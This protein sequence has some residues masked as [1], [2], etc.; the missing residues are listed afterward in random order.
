M[1]WLGG[2]VLTQNVA[3]LLAVPVAVLCMDLFLRRVTTSLLARV[4]LSLLYGFSP[5]VIS[6]L[7]VSHLM[8]AW[9]GVL[10]LIALGVVDEILVRQRHGALGAGIL[11]ALLLFAQFFL[12]SE[13]LAIVAVVAVVCVFALVVAR[14]VTDPGA[15]RARVPPMPRRDWPSGW[16]WAWC[17]W[18]GRSGSRSRAPPASPAWS[19]RTSG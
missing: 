10:P 17:S 19:G 15:V 4:V 18:P 8:T 12:S 1:T 14:L 7:A 3:L 9:I 6:S 13:L 11:L 5:Y 2:P 16:A